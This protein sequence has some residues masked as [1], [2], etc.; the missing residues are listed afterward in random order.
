MN[1]IIELASDDKVMATAED[2]T[3]APAVAT[4]SH[5]TRGPAN[6]TRALQYDQK[7]HPLDEV[8]RPS[9][10]AKRRAEHGVDA[11]EG[12]GLTDFQDQG[13][14]KSDANVDDEPHR[15]KCR[16][17][18]GSATRGILRRPVRKVTRN[19]LYNIQ[20]HPQDPQLA[21][22]DTD[23]E[24]AYEE[25]EVNSAT[26]DADDDDGVNS[27]ITDA[28]DDD[29][30]NSIT[31]DADDDDGVNSVTTEVATDKMEHLV[32]SSSSPTV[33]KFDEAYARDSSVAGE[34]ENEH[35]IY[36]TGGK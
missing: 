36:D 18:D 21:Y 34:D 1:N 32:I 5:R 20:V 17:S 29:G 6:G 10:A 22:V 9:Q 8:L 24:D 11:Q 27:I 7:Y 23:S 26:T 14:E 35:M 16:K 30:V 13:D 12:G 3:P 33:D 19:A 31:T 15:K 4:L 25:D 28:E 2:C